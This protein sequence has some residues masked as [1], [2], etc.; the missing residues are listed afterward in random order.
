MVFVSKVL[1][2]LLSVLLS[3][4]ISVGVLYCLVAGVLCLINGGEFGANCQYLW[5]VLINRR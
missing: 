4:A 1:K 3:F 5:Q 2:G